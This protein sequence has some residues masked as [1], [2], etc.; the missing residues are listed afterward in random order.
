MTEAE[1]V[2]ALTAAHDRHARAMG[3]AESEHQDGYRWGARF[4]A[5]RADAELASALQELEGVVIEYPDEEG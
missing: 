2:A 4:I 1:Y 5:E 3:V